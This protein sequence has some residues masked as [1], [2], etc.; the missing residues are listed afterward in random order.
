MPSSNAACTPSHVKPACDGRYNP[1][2]HD[3][4]S[5]EAMEDPVPSGQIIQVVVSLLRHVHSLRLHLLI[6]LWTKIR[7]HDNWIFVSS[8]IRVV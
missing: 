8:T 5:G 1:A 3:S 6:L 2:A 7:F 4:H